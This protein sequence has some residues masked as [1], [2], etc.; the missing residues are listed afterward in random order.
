VCA[1]CLSP[2]PTW[3]GVEPSY[4]FVKQKDGGVRY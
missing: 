3:L 1:D 4:V 2:L